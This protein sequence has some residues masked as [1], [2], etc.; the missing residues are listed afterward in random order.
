MRKTREEGPQQFEWIA[1][2]KDGTLFWAEVS[3]R[4]SVIGG[5]N[6]FVVIVHNIDK[7]KQ[8]ETALLQS[9]KDY[10]KLFEDHAAVKLLIDPTDGR[11]LDAN[12]AAA[13][14]YGWS[15]EELKQKYIHEINTLPPEQVKKEMEKVVAQQGIHFEFQHRRADGSVRDVEVFSSKIEYNGKEILH[16]IVHDISDKKMAERVLKAAEEKYARFFEEDLS[17]ASLS[18]ADGQILECNP[19]FIRLF[20]FTGKEEARRANFDTLYRYPAEG[21]RIRSRLQKEK[22]LERVEIEMVRTDR[23]PLHVV[24]NFVGHFDENGRLTEIQSYLF[25][26]TPAIRNPTT[27]IAEIRKHRYACKW[28]CSRF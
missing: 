7:R 12:H 16:S 13:Q 19:A 21:R 17:A 20:G 1:K 5:K 24:A 23:T 15:R 14:Y 25:D 2:R 6:R 10:K 8:M 18:T 27:G 22:R 9:Q 4:F 26:E 3:T 28:H 11:I